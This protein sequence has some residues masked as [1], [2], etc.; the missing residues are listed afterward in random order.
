MKILFCTGYHKEPINKDYW[1]NNGIGGSEY[2]SIKL[3]EKFQS[4]GHD[5]TITGEVIESESDGVKY[6]PY[7]NLESN[8]YFDV[9]IASNYI[10]YLPLLEDLNITYEKSY[11]WMHN[12]EFYPWYNGE[13]LPNGGKDYLND[14]R[15][16]KIIAV[17]EHQRKNIIM[18]Y[19][20]DPERVFVLGN[21]IDPID[22]D[23][24]EQ[25]TF[26]NKIVY[27]SA[28]DRG[29]EVLIKLWP[30]LKKIN[31][32]LTLWVASPPYAMEW[33]ND[34]KKRM[35]YQDVKWLGN[36]P[37]ADL[38]K[39][40]KSAEYW[41]YPSNY[42]ETYC[43]TAL[44]M[45]MGRTKIISTDT[46][47]LKSLLNG[48]A[49]IVRA[50]T[51]ETIQEATFLST[52]EF[53]EENGYDYLDVAEKFARQQNWET[54]SNEWIDMINTS[55]KIPTGA[56][57]FKVRSTNENIDK[58]HP[59]LY[60]YWDNKKEWESK[61][62]T[63]SVR[64]K[65]WDLIIDE[66]FNNCLSFPLFTEDFCKMIR[67]EAEHSQ[68][69]TFKRHEFYPTT[70]MLLTEIG[71]DDIYNA[72]LKD[73]VMQL[74]VYIYGLEGEGWDDLQCENFLAK[75][76]PDAQGHLSIHHD[77]SDLTCLVQLSDLDEYE[78]GGTYFKRQQKLVKNSIG[79]A[80]LHP[81]NITHKHGARATTKGTRYITVSFMK[82][83]ER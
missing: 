43:I 35:F 74:G 70:D 29:L 48:K 8:T 25:E 75:Y 60:S 55:I 80:T 24:I 28:S 53:I 47:N 32:Y 41:M 2:C 45:M 4:M 33:Y 20:L 54:R 14:P 52:Y 38:Y 83:R 44:E 50:D 10:N 62:L 23:E 42:D 69:W 26:K 17:S 34:Y 40:I 73:Y 77:S 79:Y 81:G 18:D 72:V 1:L 36:L 13:E 5:V 49:A 51:S 30:S 71:M 78:G 46:G 59:E 16:T 12:M 68:K 67:E 19:N 66:P 11:F 63:Y 65:E 6:I 64:T 9:V 3:A 39:Q 57:T 76:V 21:A 82:N 15:L 37:P 31:P 56:H 27:T 22:F 61:F 7:A 58:L